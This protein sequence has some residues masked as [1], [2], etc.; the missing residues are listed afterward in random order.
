MLLPLAQI[1][2]FDVALNGINSTAIF[3]PFFFEEILKYW[4]LRG[5]RW[6]TCS[7]NSYHNGSIIFRLGLCAEQSSKS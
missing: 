4:R 1:T 3:P 7:D 5:F 6:S 2:Q